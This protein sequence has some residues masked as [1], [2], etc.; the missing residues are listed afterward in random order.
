MTIIA[1]KLNMKYLVVVFLTISIQLF[2]QNTIDGAINKYN[3]HSIEYISTVELQE[4]LSEKEQVSLL[5][6]REK[7]EFEVS[8]L[9][10]AIWLGYS[11]LNLSA[12]EDIDK[13][14]TLIVYCS[15]GVRSEQVGEKLSD[16]GF[17]N[18]YNL[19]GGI[20][21]W[22]NSSYPIYDTLNQKTQKIQGFD[23][24]WGNL[25]TK[26]EKVFE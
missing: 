3:S 18:I 25:L 15:I 1:L 11:S 23:S 6:T 10:N 12:I 14:S 9:Q 21:K 4:K 2:G 20:F 13:S 16:M 26:G 7:K 8:H 17:E 19:Y 22:V 24:H 5:D